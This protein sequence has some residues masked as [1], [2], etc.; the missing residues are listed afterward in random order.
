[1][2]AVCDKSR[3]FIVALWF[4]VISECAGCGVYYT[5][6]WPVMSPDDA[7][8]ARLSWKVT[9]SDLRLGL[10]LGSYSKSWALEW[11]TTEDPARLYRARLHWEAG[12]MALAKGRQGWD[13]ED[14]REVRFS[15]D[16]QHVA[17]LSTFRLLVVNL[18]SGRSRQIAHIGLPWPW[19]VKQFVSMAWL[20]EDEICYAQQSVGLKRRLGSVCKWTLFR[21]DI[22]RLWSRP[23]VIVEVEGEGT[24]SFPPDYVSNIVQWAPNGRHALFAWPHPDGNLV[25]VDVIAGT[26]HVVRRRRASFRQVAWRP[27]GSA[28]LCGLW[29]V[30]S[31]YSW[32]LVDTLRRKAVDLTQR[33][34]NLC[35]AEGYLT[36]LVLEPLWTADGH[37]VVANDMSTMESST[38]GRAYLIRPAPWQIVSVNDLLRDH[39]HARGA[40]DVRAEPAALPGWIRVTAGRKTY[41]M[42]YRGQHLVEIPPFAMVST[43][44][45]QVVTWE[46]YPEEHLEIRPLALPQ[47]VEPVTRPVT[48]GYP[49]TGE[50][51]KKAQGGSA[52][53]PGAGKENRAETAPTR[54]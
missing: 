15:P 20:N 30:N 12:L 44:A 28:A 7:A 1:M 45:K 34:E 47:A 25:L 29:D 49:V 22:K 53:K 17:V 48:G 32:V 51:L 14:W 24:M 27:D 10:L 33:M 8:V 4:F 23:L 2:R 18:N 26:Q 5:S 21:R 39:L 3:W 43:T 36:G 35:P 37:F 13:F 38:G 16:S 50:G 6:K 31:R 46:E 52:T 42:D 9:H 41:L 19:H 54:P 11:F 40:L